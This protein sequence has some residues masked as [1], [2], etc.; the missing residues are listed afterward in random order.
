MMYAAPPRMI[1]IELEHGMIV[2]QRIVGCLSYGRLRIIRIFSAVIML[3]TSIPVCLL[4]FTNKDIRCRNYRKYELSVQ[5]CANIN[6][7]IFE[8]IFS[9]LLCSLSYGFAWVFRYS[10]R[11]TELFTWLAML[12]STWTVYSIWLDNIRKSLDSQHT[13]VRLRLLCKRNE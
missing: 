6:L 4:I 10:C 13:V 5:V 7:L 12:L 2:F 9:S 3:F 8:C 1:D 11:T